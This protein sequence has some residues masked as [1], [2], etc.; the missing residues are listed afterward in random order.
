V[1]LAIYGLQGEVVR[2][3]AD[4][5]GAAGP[6]HVAWDGRDEAGHAVAAGAYF[7]RLEAFG[8]TLTTRM[9]WMR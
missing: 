6:N 5:Q 7:V 2:T 3:L 4:G 9:V 8:R 1:R